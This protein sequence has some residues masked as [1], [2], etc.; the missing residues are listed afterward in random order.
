MGSVLQEKLTEI[1]Q[2][3]KVMKESWVAEI[4]DGGNT[5]LAIYV[6][7]W[8]GEELIAA[9]QCP[10]DRDTAL[11]AA[12]IGAMGFSADTVSITFESWHSTHKQSP[13]TG[14]NWRPREMQF[15]GETNPEAVAKRWVNECLTTSIHDREGNYGISSEPFQIEG[16]GGDRKVV[17]L[18]ADAQMRISSENENER[19][20]GFMFNVLQK[21]MSE[22]KM[23]EL[24]AEQVQQ[25]PLFEVLDAVISDPEL[26]Y[27][28]TDSATVQAMAEREVALA[29]V[30]NAEKGSER[31]RLI[32]ERFGEAMV[33]F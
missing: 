12:H 11:N 25:N 14:E 10:L 24:M 16:E 3:M 27:Y 30:L 13:I 19:G 8:R 1:T 4:E 20:D 17:W 18:E 6:H 31:Y 21:I 5:D 23:T 9:A 15:V 29:V 28:H 7:F 22:K 2:R 33:Q 26:R 32:K